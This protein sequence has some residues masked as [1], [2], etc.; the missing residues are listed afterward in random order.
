[1]RKGE[2]DNP[3]VVLFAVCAG[4][5]LFAPIFMKII[6]TTSSSVSEKF[7]NVS[8]AAGA[9]T[10]HIFTSTAN[11]WD[12]FMI[13]LFVAVIL[14][15]IISS[16]LI[17]TH[18]VF[19]IVYIISAFFLIIFTPS[20]IEGIQIVYNQPSFVLETAQ[21]SLTTFLL[22][23]FGEFLVGI[24]MLTGIIIYGKIRY[25]GASNNQ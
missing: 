13:G 9:T 19:V 4:L 15:M 25:F 18:P 10:S 21:L 12:Y 11:M 7:G 23:H 20:I 2:M 24:Y 6:N 16:F 5:F 17:D 3:L 22:D 1:M 14:F 8:V